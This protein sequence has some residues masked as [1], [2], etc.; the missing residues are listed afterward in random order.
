MER[1]ISDRMFKKPVYGVIRSIFS[2]D[3][4]A[5][6]SSRGKRPFI[7]SLF[8]ALA[9]LCLLLPYGCSST[10]VNVREDET[11]GDKMP[12]IWPPP[13]EPARISYVMAIS[14]PADIGAG[15]GFFRKVMEFILGESRDD[16]IKPYGVAVDSAG[17]LIVADTAFKRVHIFDIKKNKYSFIES[18][19]EG[20]LESPISAAIDAEDN[21]YVTDSVRR[22]VYVYGKDG[23]YLSEFE[24]G[25]RPTGIAVNSRDK[26]VF[27][28]D[29]GG[30]R[31]RVFDLKGKKITS[32]G[33]LGGGDGEFNFPV[34]IAIDRNGDL[35]VV[36][37]MNYRIQIFDR[38][39]KFV[40]KF[41]RQGDATGDFGRPK[42]VAVDGD[43][44]I[45]VADALFDT[46]QIFDR[47]GDFLLNFGSL[48]GDKGS[49]WM[50]CGVFADSMDKIYVADSYNGR[51]QVFEYIG[52][53]I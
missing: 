48:G 2:R 52:G 50:P 28:V 17:R 31:I 13:P 7:R 9:L 27:V 16:I 47:K 4:D 21:I 10:N 36:D 3:L 37:T 49:F 46:V 24:A 33:E 25:E 42:G 32:F 53:D 18:A 6:D 45:Y 35:Y 5:M 20:T 15:K 1:L 34:D 51:V 29:T 22:K 43:G 11:R 40:A 39:A 12:L 38:N 14:R 8:L 44:N 41:G 26:R 23:R 30:N 19:G